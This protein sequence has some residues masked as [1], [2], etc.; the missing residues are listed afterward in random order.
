MT[1]ISDQDRAEAEA[2]VGVY[3]GRVSAGALS[4][5]FVPRWLAVR[6]R[7]LAAH[8]CPTVPVWRPTTADE[9]QPGWEVRSRHRHGSEA[10]W[11]VADRQDADGDW[12]SVAR[13]LTNAAGGWTYETT[14]PVSEPKPDPRVDVV[15]RELHDRSACEDAWPS[16]TVSTVEHY[17]GSARDLLARLDALTEGGQS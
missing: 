11:G 5:N 12:Y 16:C 8:E 1:T 2:M 7:V 14:A 4:D 10:T 17:R 6:D 15:A 13:L 9:I 3:H